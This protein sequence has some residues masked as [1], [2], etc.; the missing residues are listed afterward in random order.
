MFI[1]I[2]AVFWYLCNVAMLS[3]GLDYITGWQAL[4]IGVV[5]CLCPVYNKQVKRLVLY[6]M[7]FVIVLHWLNLVS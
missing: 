1:L 3:L 2:A 7:I 4:A 5:I 6:S